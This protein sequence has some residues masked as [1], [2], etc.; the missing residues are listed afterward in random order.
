MRTPA[1]G[2]F[3]NQPLTDETGFSPA[4]KTTISRLAK[5]SQSRSTITGMIPVRAA[6]VDDLEQLRSLRNHYVASSHATFDEVP[7]AP[8]AIRQWF[9]SFAVSG[10]YRLLV[11][12]EA[13]R[14]LGFASSQQ[15]RVHPA[16]HKTVETSVYVAPGSSQRGVGS[17]LYK[18]LFAAILN[19]GLHCA[20]A[21]I[22][23]PNDASIALHKKF[24][25]VEV[26]IF[27]QYAVKNGQFISSLW[28]QRLF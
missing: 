9:D 4:A 25:F 17:A 1:P 2:A 14:I 21:G 6:N 18:N 15:Y 19:E 3:K 7:L 16:F 12:E 28:M 22:A 13:G 23:L 24:G 11:A 20:V 27:N 26:G 5:A 8:C 10:A